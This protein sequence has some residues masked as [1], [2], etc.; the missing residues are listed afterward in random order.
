MLMLAQEANQRLQ[1]LPR[2]IF[3]TSSRIQP[4]QLLLQALPDCLAADFLQYKILGPATI[5][6]SVHAQA[7][8]GSSIVRHTRDLQ[9]QA[10][11]GL[12]RRSASQRVHLPL[13][14]AHL[15]S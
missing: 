1:H 2:I 4:F 3:L 8:R 10:K 5:V 12:R 7:Q 15:I 13:T 14:L 11:Q 6:S 9:Q